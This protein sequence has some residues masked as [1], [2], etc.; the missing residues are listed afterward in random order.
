M[1][2]GMLGLVLVCTLLLG[3]VS[4]VEAVTFTSPNFSINGALG[5]SVAGQPGSTNYKM[6]AS[7]GESII[8]DGASGSY[9]L[10][11]GY[12]A[13]LERSFQLNVQPNG[14]TAYYPMD[15]NTGTVA[16]DSSATAL[17][18]SLQATPTWTTG[19]V[20]NALLFNGTTQ[21]VALND[22]DI[23]GS[24]ITVAAW[25]YPTSATQTAKVV[26]KQTATTDVQGTLSLSA[27]KAQFEVTTGG[28]YRNPIGTTTLPINTWSYI[29]GTYD[30][31]NAK[32]YV[33]GALEATVAGTGT[34][35]NNNVGWAIA[36]LNATTSSNYF[37][38]RVDEVKIYSLAFIDKSVEAEYDGGVAGFPAGVSLGSL[39]P[40]TSQTASFNAIAQTDAPGYT[41]AINQN[42]NLTSGANTISPVSGSIASPVSWTEGT[43]KGLGF[44]LYATTATA[45]P[46]TWNSGN[47]YAAI[48]NT[49]A[50]FYTRTGLT[51]GGKDVLSMRFRL[52]TTT[53]QPNGDYTNQMTII[54]T[55]TP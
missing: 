47:S 11:Q 26:S 32:I 5:N 37:A 42:N 12:A 34:L 43:T 51:A 39:T 2:R 27:G 55:M 25:V 28:T 24:A 13:S 50:T 22:T 41:L 49:A 18:G 14:L 6:E 36:R 30:G 3:S 1:I 17:N 21:Y 4:V 33:N 44:T 20:G 7:G 15:E 52:D 8:G 38:G 29:V 31:A 54:G 19:K 35:A 16:Y 40:G 46:G 10:G 9:K 23:A 53:S 48:P 45:I